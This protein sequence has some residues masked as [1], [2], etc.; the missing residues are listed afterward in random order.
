VEDKEWRVVLY[1]QYCN[2]KDPLST[3]KDQ[4][5]I[6]ERLNLTGRIR[7]SPEGI[8]GCIGGH[9]LKIQEYITAVDKI[10]EF[11]AQR[12]PIHWKLS[13]F[14]Q[15]DLKSKKDLLSQ[16][17]KTLSVKVVKEVV[18]LDLSEISTM[19]MIKAGP[20]EHLSPQEFH[21][22]L[23]THI[24]AHKKDDSS[25]ID[26]IT[27]PEDRYLSGTDLITVPEDRYFKYTFENID[28]LS[29]SSNPHGNRRDGGDSTGD[30]GS[31]S[32][33]NNGSISRLQH[34]SNDIDFID[35][36]KNDLVVIDVRNYYETRIGRFQLK[37]DD[38]NVVS[39]IDPKT[40]QFSDFAKFVDSNVEDFLG[41][42]VLM[43][44]TG[45]VRCERAS[46][47]MKSKGVDDVS[48]LSGGIH[49][50][51]E[52]YPG[53]NSLFHGKN[54]VFDPRISVPSEGSAGDE[55]VG[56]CTVCLNPYDDYSRQIRCNKCRVLLLLC[57]SCYISKNEDL[58]LEG[59]KRANF[60]KSLLCEQCIK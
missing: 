50:Y 32:D 11:D 40:R 42:K 7:V 13:G 45:G 4:S 29:S 26:L 46:A 44:C 55:I 51:Q 39:V 25:G 35:K 17:F 30:D 22:I 47:Y 57:D 53:N 58:N 27:A 9:F 23:I 14:S 36:T 6:C 49:A 28:V 16:R 18:S 33:G 20:G 12:N 2:L 31:G 52:S 21:R 59:D 10:M 8:N 24:N 56:T 34:N 1:Y 41:K 60:L 5:E 43:Y 37:E 54:F 15:M 19:E 38:S 3:R 48:Q